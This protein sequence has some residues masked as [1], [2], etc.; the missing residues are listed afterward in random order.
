[1]QKVLVCV[2]L[3]GVFFAAWIIWTPQASRDDWERKAVSEKAEGS[4][5]AGA[6]EGSDSR[7]PKEANDSGDETPAI[8]P[9][10]EEALRVDAFD[11]LSDRWMAPSKDGI[12]FEQVA[13]FLKAFG[14]VPEESKTLCL[15]RALNLIPDENVM[16]LAG[17]LFDKTQ[18]KERLE[19]VFNDILNR[20]EQCKMPIIRRIYKDKSHPCW[21]DAAWILEAMGEVGL[22]ER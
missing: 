14:S 22:P 9:V 5:I 15:Q 2:G 4:D 11:S 1:M 6:A 8:D 10:D 20:A 7:E 16:L 19:L 21:S 13:E 3:A 18:E 12:S 17:V